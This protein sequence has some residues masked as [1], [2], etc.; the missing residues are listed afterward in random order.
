MNDQVF[1]DVLE[2]LLALRDNAYQAFQAKLMPTVPS[3]NT[4]RRTTGTR[5]SSNKS[6]IM[7]GR[8]HGSQSGDWIFGHTIKRFKKPWKAIVS[9]QK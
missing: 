2:Q 7:T 3:T 5:F 1:T 8:C 9:Q 4:T 6:G